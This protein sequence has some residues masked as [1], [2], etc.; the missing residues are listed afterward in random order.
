MLFGIIE[1]NYEKVSFY[2]SVSSALSF[3]IFNLQLHLSCSKVVFEDKSKQLHKIS[4]KGHHF[5]TV[6]P[7]YVLAHLHIEECLQSLRN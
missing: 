3:P 5:Y 2:E 1:E 4:F 6:N 7:Y